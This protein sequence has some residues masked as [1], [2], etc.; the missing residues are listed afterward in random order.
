M[1]DDS[2]RT[3]LLFK[4]VAQ[5]ALVDALLQAVDNRRPK[6]TEAI[7]RANRIQTWSS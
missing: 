3:A 6:I 7:E 1:R 2:A 4:P 5:I